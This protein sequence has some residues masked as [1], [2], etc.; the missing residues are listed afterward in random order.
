MSQ[1]HWHLLAESS[2]AISGAYWWIWVK[3]RNLNLSRFWSAISWK[4]WRGFAWCPRIVLVILIKDA[5]KR[6]SCSRKNGCG[7]FY[8]FLPKIIFTQ[9]STAE[10]S[11]ISKPPSQFHECD[12][13]FENDFP[14]VKKMAQNA[15][16]GFH[17]QFWFHGKKSTASGGAK[18]RQHLH[19][20]RSCYKTP[21]K[22]PLITKHP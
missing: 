21:L 3:R 16:N 11:W 7:S 20:W 6:S 4:R 13:V 8:F 18:H 14:P 2:D 5:R 10:K 19:A 9:N 1:T 12:G 22:Y 17:A 15:K